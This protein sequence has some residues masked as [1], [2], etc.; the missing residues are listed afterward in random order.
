MQTPVSCVPIIL[1][2]VANSE[3]NTFCCLHEDCVNCKFIKDTRKKKTTNLHGAPNVE[4][5]EGTQKYME[6]RK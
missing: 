1:Y 3:D 2:I 4:G 5:E 6:R